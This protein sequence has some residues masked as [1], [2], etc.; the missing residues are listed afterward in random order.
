MA[1]RSDELTRFVREALIRG[2]PRA[3]IERTL[4]EA[5]WQPDQVHKALACFAEVDFAIPVPRPVPHVSAGEAFLYLVLFTALGLSAF[6][7]VE[8]YF[9]L[10]EYWFHDPASAARFDG[11][12]SV[13]GIRWSVANAAIA[14][15]VFLVAS[16]LIARSLRRD[17]TARGSAVRRWLTYLAMF[18]AVLVIV[19][20]AVAL[21]AYVLS[22]GTTARFL[23]KVLVVALVA[24]LI[25]GF[26]LW[27]MRETDRVRRPAA[28]RFLVVSVLVWLVAV[29]SGLWL[30]G[31]PS[32]QAARRIDERRVEDLRWLA[33]GVDRYYAQND[34]L[35][36]NIGAMSSALETTFPERD[37]VTYEP[38]RYTAGAGKTF[39]LCADFTHP[40]GDDMAPDSVWTHG[41]GTQCFAL[42]ADDEGR[43]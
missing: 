6:S 18:L 11:G 13:S 22:G 5:G 32:E 7:V 27:D 2:V 39:E 30:M 43:R 25:L 9:A 4:L 8:L 17:P 33:R 21:V 12:A 19:G 16:W 14:F 40:A 37:P 3:E 1:A 29:G 31:S 28:M 24:C 15:P 41:A 20:D 23:L 38:Y 42:T 26:Y 36:R 35:P 34:A 10:I